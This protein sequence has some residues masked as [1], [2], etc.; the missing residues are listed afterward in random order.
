LSIEFY[1][2]ISTNQTFAQSGININSSVVNKSSNVF[3][4]N[5]SLTNNLFLIAHSNLNSSLSASS[6]SSA[7]VSSA[8]NEV[9]GDFNG[10][11]FEDLVIGVPG[12]DLFTDAGTVI[13]AG[14]VNVIYGSS[15]GLSITPL[16]PDQFWTQDTADVD[17]VAEAGD[18]F[19]FS[20][21]AGDFNGDGK[22]DLAVG[23]LYE[24][25]LMEPGTIIED[26]GA[27]NVIYGSAN[28]L[29]ATSPIPDQF[30]SQGETGVDGIAE[31]TDN[32]G[33][34]LSAAD[35]NGDGNDD[36][37]IGVPGEDMI[38]TA[39]TITNAGAVNVIYGSSSGLSDTSSSPD[40]FLSQGFARIND[41][42]EDSDLFGSSLS[43]ADFNGDGKDDLAIG[44]PYEDVVT[45][46][47]TIV[48]TGAVNVIYGSAN[49]LSATS[50]PDQF[51]LQGIAGIN[52]IAEDSDYF[53]YSLSGSDFN[54]DRKDD[55]A[56]GVPAEDL[57]T[58][59]GTIVDTGAV[60][61]LYGSA[62]GLSTTSPIP[63][64]FFTQGVAGVNDVAEVI[65]GFGFSIA[66]A[67]FNGDYGRNDLAIGVPFEDV[68]TTT[69]TVADVGAVNVIYGSANG[70]STTSTPDQ[71]FVQGIA[72]VNDLAEETDAFGMSLA[73]SDF[74]GDRMDELAIGIPYEDMV[75]PDGTIVNA[76]AVNVI[77]GS[78]N[79][80][81][82]TSTADQFL[83][84]GIAGVNDRAE[85]WDMFGFPLG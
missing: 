41:A 31:T 30:F 3:I 26:S 19:G 71:F 62:N 45:T 38:R 32:F 5:N 80:L 55:I 14:A 17:D 70:L 28:G 54:G 47:G 83:L 72:G 77:Y 37:V 59:T 15:S 49:G 12:E 46:T 27:V 52:D 7:V 24:D 64:Q 73:S 68:Q 76:G 50:T 48:D 20:L 11:G 53:G 79:G 10:D 44:V 51:L 4:S 81:S 36:L 58:A 78:A 29:S 69:G 8:T 1:C 35:F 57:V 61:V 60:N 63:D 23:V 65:E 13:N 21:S 84:Q 82:T 85:E 33:Y 22:D 18:F 39:G 43:A 66:A 67:D 16:R 56:I 34:S 74:N 9:I 25:V 6:S 40:Q 75:T 2:E 42:P